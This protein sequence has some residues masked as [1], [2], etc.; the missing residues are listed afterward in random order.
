MKL[1]TNILP[2]LVCVVPC[3]HGADKMPPSEFLSDVAEFNE[4]RDLCEHFLGE[5]PYDEERR[6]FLEEKLK[7]Y[8]TGTDKVLSS[9]RTK[10]RNNKTVLKALADYGENIE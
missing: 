2:G 4:R 9:L 5:E 3:S 6:K 7:K 1:L 8:C 10:Y